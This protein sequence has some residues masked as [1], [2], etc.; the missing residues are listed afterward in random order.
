MEE[1]AV[2]REPSLAG[3]AILALERGHDRRGRVVVQI[4]ELPA[5]VMNHVGNGGAGPR[6]GTGECRGRVRDGDVLRELGNVGDR[7]EQHGLPR[8]IELRRGLLET[9]MQ[10]VSLPPPSRRLGMFHIVSPGEHLDVGTFDEIVRIGDPAGGIILGDIVDQRHHLDFRL[11]DIALPTF[12]HHLADG[13]P[14][15]HLAGL[16]KD[17]MLAY[18]VHEGIEAGSPKTAFDFPNLGREQPGAAQKHRR[19]GPL[20]AVAQGGPRGFGS[21]YPRGLGPIQEHDVK[22][23]G[24]VP[25]EPAPADHGHVAAVQLEEPFEFTGAGRAGFAHIQHLQQVQ[26]RRASRRQQDQPRRQRDAPRF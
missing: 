20:L 19:F 1:P 26:V 21:V 8:F 7:I 12:G 3:G 14:E 6:I 9:E 4:I 10:Q 2:F 15:A 16:L 24:L 11:L 13:F 17:L 22:I 23:F 25:L 5:G 18:A